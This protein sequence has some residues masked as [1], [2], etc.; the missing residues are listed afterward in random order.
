MSA[1]DAFTRARTVDTP[2]LRLVVVPHAGGSGNVYYPM[3]RS[4]PPTWE[5]LLLDLPGRGR[6]HT[7]DPLV[8][9]TSVVARVTDDILAVSDAT[10]TAI[11]GH[12]LGAV[13]AFEAARSLQAQG[14][15]PVW[16]GVSG[17]QAPVLQ[18]ANRLLDPSLSDVELAR[19][20]ARLGGLP[21]RLDEL[22]EFRDRFIKLIRADLRALDSYRPDPQRQPLT[23]P[24]TVFASTDDAMAAPSGASAWGRETTMGLRQQVFD[25]G[26]FHFFGETFP[27]FTAVLASEI[28]H[29]LG[30]LEAAAPGT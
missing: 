7:S 8:D 3:S 18:P 11:F 10:P 27:A 4:L 12:S 25:G 2:T 30:R 14:A 5:L 23:C 16:V 20:L 1:A 17:R 22:P 9:M 24:L 21:A 15:A 26:H 13:I 19:R 29:A 6:R 28:Q